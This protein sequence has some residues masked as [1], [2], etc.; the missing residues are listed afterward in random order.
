MWIL[1]LNNSIKIKKVEDIWKI[2]IENLREM[3]KCKLE[4]YGFLKWCKLD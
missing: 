3:K 4:K 1:F 2:V